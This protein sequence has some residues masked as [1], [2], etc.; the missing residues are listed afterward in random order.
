MICEILSVGTELLMGQIANTDAQYLSRRLSELGVTLYRQSV[1]GDNPARVKEA[2]SQALAR[3]DMVITTGGL[4]PTED[5]LTKEMVA[6]YFGLEMMLDE[7]SL[8]ALK[9]RMHA[10]A[11]PMTDNNYKQAYFPKGAIIMPNERGTAPGCI[12][13]LGDKTVAV[14]PGPPRELTDMFEKRLAPYLEAR[15]GHKI[16]SRFIKIFGLGESNVETMLLD[17]FHTDNPTLALYC[18]T[19]EVSARVSARVKTGED[20]DNMI[21][22]LIAEIKRRCGDAVYAE[23]EKCGMARATLN[24]LLKRGE[25]V[26]FAESCTG[27]MLTSEFVGTPGASEA[28]TESVV[29]Y[30]NASKTRLLDVKPETLEKF[31]AVSE[32]CAREMA[33]GML[34]ISGA[35][36]AVSVTGI[37]GPGG[38]SAEKPVGTVCMA[39]ARKNFTRAVT[40]NFVG[41]REWIRMLSTA[42]AL[43][44]LRLCVLEAE[45]S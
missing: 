28:L 22:P 45:N 3:A 38:G 33:E 29:T 31:G 14:L 19:G 13:E 11:R 39:V 20:A 41:D 24:L 9:K 10:A 43:N 6:E 26:A 2:L 23:E 7:P 5:D 12:V 8:E 36:W 44:M 25:T 21:A 40:R 27:G 37:A 34:K 18:G 1:V 30:T 42:H 16:V 15:S 4:G 32:Q 35:D 17:L